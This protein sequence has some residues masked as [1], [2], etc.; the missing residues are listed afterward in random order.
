M[1]SLNTQNSESRNFT[2]D[3]ARKFAKIAEEIFAP[4]YPVI[5][6]NIFRETGISSGRCIDLGSGP[7][8]LG[9]ALAARN[10]ELEIV[11]YDQSEEM[12]AIAQTRCLSTSFA[13]RVTMQQGK[14]EDIPFSDNSAQ[15]IVSRGSVFFWE[16]QLQA[17]NEIY[18]VLA[19][20]GFA[21]I[22]GGF[23]NETLQ[24]KICE[25][26]RAVDSDWGA[27]RKKRMG[28]Q[29]TEHFTTLLQQSIVDNYKISQEKAG[30]WIIFKK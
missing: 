10:P 16:D 19:P 28:T 21:Y 27:T 17:I 14:A 13:D 20:G 25:E 23:G 8:H 6:D 12:L 1:T 11:L 18:R 3:S 29:S 4:I 24:L 26:M 30:L 22:G 9:L 15:L 7:G 5:A 2:G